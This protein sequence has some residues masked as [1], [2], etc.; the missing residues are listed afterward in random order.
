MNRYGHPFDGHDTTLID[1]LDA[2]HDEAAAPTNNV[3]A[4]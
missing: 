3:V 2:A 1:R 4:L